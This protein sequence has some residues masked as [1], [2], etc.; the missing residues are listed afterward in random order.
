MQCKFRLV[1]KK[2]KKKEKENGI[3]P[4]K[5]I[6]PT[7][8][9]STHF[10]RTL[11]FLGNQTDP[12]PLKSKKRMWTNVERDK[13]YGGKSLRQRKKGKS[14][15]LGS[16]LVRFVRSINGVRNGSLEKKNMNIFWGSVWVGVRV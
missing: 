9:P 7:K 16:K 14:S 1:D 3:T 13:M 10:L 4:H 6:Q 2:S 15:R 5:Q 8:I 12:E 11:N